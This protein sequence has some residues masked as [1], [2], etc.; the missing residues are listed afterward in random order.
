[1]YILC[2]CLL[3]PLI[4]NGFSLIGEETDLNSLSS[5]EAVDDFKE[6]FEI[7][8]TDNQP[9]VVVYDGIS[10]LELEEICKD[11]D[12]LVYILQ[13]DITIDCKAFNSGDRPIDAPKKVIKR[14]IEDEV[15]GSGSG[16]THDNIEE[17]FAGEPDENLKSD[18][19]DEINDPVP[20]FASE[21]NQKEDSEIVTPNGTNEDDIQTVNTE[22]PA[23]E[24]K[25]NDALSGPKIET[26]NSEPDKPNAT[27]EEAS[28]TVHTGTP[29]EPTEKT[30]D[31]QEK[32]MENSGP[33][34]VE[35][36]NQ[37]TNQPIISD[38]ESVSEKK[39]NETT[40]EL[41]QHTTMQSEEGPKL[42]Q[43]NISQDLNETDE[44]SPDSSSENGNI[45][46]ES[47]EQPLTPPAT[48]NNE[49]LTPSN[50]VNQPVPDGNLGS[51]T[52]A[53]NNN[54]ETTIKTTSDNGN[55]EIPTTT[56]ASITEPPTDEEKKQQPNDEMTVPQKSDNDNQAGWIS[57]PEQNTEGKSLIPP[58]KSEEMQIKEDATESE[59]ADSPAQSSKKAGSKDTTILVF[60]FV[61][62]VVVGALAFGYNFI[63]KRKR[64]SADLERAERTPVTKLSL[65]NL[66]KTDE[67]EK[68][69][70]MSDTK[71]VEMV[72][73]KRDN[74]APEQTPE[75][76]N[77]DTT[78][79]T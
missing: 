51:D 28:E 46:N 63:K 59:N 53:E 71:E 50:E 70:L 60:L 19:G 1:M 10:R 65:Q 34:T 13:E 22:T 72:D 43:A 74:S 54:T 76:A 2:I 67:P 7:W 33:Q 77:N 9:D 5:Y 32:E 25:I 64:Q 36:D 23:E 37:D 73:M 31:Q 48:N 49:I 30:N 4:Q 44:E 12:T 3:A 79:R 78:V 62:V 27:N 39:E 8:N 42:R 26:G 45:D 15:E 14:S 17:N 68:K 55:E 66:A 56:A 57:K 20:T 41:G 16:P 6:N 35:T 47:S 52:N 75:T 24:P 29:L 40:D 21:Y 11:S 61:A 38:A 69:P 58:K 18:T